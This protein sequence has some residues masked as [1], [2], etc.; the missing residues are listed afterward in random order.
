[1][2]AGRLAADLERETLLGERVGG[3]YWK[4]Q[5]A[6]AERAQRG[7]LPTVAPL[8]DHW[9]TA[10][11]VGQADPLGGDFFDWFCL[12][13]GW[14]AVGLGDA[15]ARGIEGALSAS[16]V[17]AALRSHAQYQ[18]GPEQLLG[19][20][21]LTLW[22]GSA[23]D[24][25][26]NLFAGLVET[27]TG[28]IHFGSAGQLGVVVVRPGGWESLTQPSAALGVGPETQYEPQYYELR[29]GEALVVF[30]DGFREAQDGRGR[31]LGEGGLAESLVLHA[32]ASAEELV[33]IARDRLLTHAVDPAKMDRAILVVKRTPT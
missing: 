19:H 32:N 14:L 1:V 11:W 5:V 9:E 21:N 12:P 28:R 33:Q 8:L 24:Q 17:K 18:R 31:P 16:A 22:T 25:S 7:S 23:G 27:A 15:A 2:T 30:S 29:P 3:A 10:G 4:H 20:V 26:A 6:A 13:E